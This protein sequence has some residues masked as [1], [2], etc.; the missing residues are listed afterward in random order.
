MV[1]MY[2]ISTP[3]IIMS[4]TMYGM[5][6]KNLPCTVHFTLDRLM[7]TEVKRLLN[8]PRTDAERIVHVPFRFTFVRTTRV[9]QLNFM[10]VQR[11]YLSRISNACSCVIEKLSAIQ[12]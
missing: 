6:K 4:Y 11:M 5:C 3:T 9:L 8:G 10:R 12:C 7:K 2:T 1:H